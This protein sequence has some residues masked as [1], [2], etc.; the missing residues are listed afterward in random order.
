MREQLL[1]VRRDGMWKYLMTWFKARAFQREGG[2][3]V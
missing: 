3:N 2:G 1:A